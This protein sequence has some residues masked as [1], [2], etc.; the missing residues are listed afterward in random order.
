MLFAIFSVLGIFVLPLLS[1]QL[2][3]SKALPSVTVN[4]SW[5]N[6]SP[7]VLE[8]EITAVL[9]SGF[10]TI[11]GLE[12][13]NSKSSKGSGSI[14]MS[15]D[16]YTD[17]TTARYEIASLIRQLYSELPEN[18][19]YPTTHV[20]RPDEEEKSAFLTYSISAKR[21]P[22]LIH[23]WVK[24]NIEPIIGALEGIDNIQIN[25][26]TANEYILSY[27]NNQLKQLQ[28]S[29]Q[30]LIR[31][32][33]QKFRNESLGTIS[34]NGNFITVSAKPRQEFLEWNFPVGKINNNIIY[35]DDICT[36]EKREKELQSYYRVNGKN[37]ITMSVFASKKVN[38]ITLTNVV[39]KQINS[40]LKT[41]PKDFN[42]TKD[43]DSSLYLKNELNKIYERSIYTLLL[44]L[45]FVWIVSKSI[46]YL[47]VTVIAIFSNISI[48]FILYYL[49]N[50]EIQL[51]SLAG[52][53]ISLGLIVDNCIVMIDHIRHQ[54]NIN[55]FIPILA[56]TLTTIGALSIIYFLDKE[57]SV[58][59]LDF[60]LVIIVNLT[61]SLLVA[62]LLIPALLKKIHLPLKKEKEV[63][64]NI[65]DTFYIKYEKIISQLL[66]FK[67]L[68]IL[69]AILSFGLPFFLLP[70][71]FEENDKWYAK[72]YNTTLGSEWYLE[73]VRPH[74]DTYL[75]GTFRLFSN[76]V[77]ENAY[78]GKNEET[79]LFID[80][81][82]EKG[83]TVHQMNDAFLDI[84]HYLKNFKGIKSFI[85]N[86]E[87]GNYGRIEITFTNDSKPSYPYLVKSKLI[88]KT[89]ELGGMDWNIFGVGR[90]FF[91]NR[92]DA[93]QPV[94][95][96]LEAKG[97]NYKELNRWADTLKTDLETHPR[98]QEVFVRENS[99]VK[100]RPSFEYT[101]NLDKEKLAVLNKSPLLLINELKQLTI[102]KQEDLN[103][104]INGKLMPIRFKSDDSE[105]FDIWHINNVPLDSLLGPVLLKDLS[106]IEK[107]KADEN[108]Y[109][110]NQE[111][112][113]L[114]EFDYT[115]VRKFGSD[116]LKEKLKRLEKKL[117]LG[118][119]FVVAKHRGFKQ[120]QNINYSFLLILVLGIIYLICAI[121]FESLKQPFI[122]LSIVPISFVG[123]FLTF[124]W[125]D[126]NFDQGG[127]ASF[128][129]LSGITVNASIFIVN[130]FNRLKKKYPDMDIKSLYIEAFRQKIFP[131]MLTVLSTI[132]GFIPFVK[133]GQNEVF[134]FALGV[135][136]MGGLLFSLIGILFY[137][138]VFTLKNK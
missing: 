62:L 13:I 21:S 83:S 51:Y 112:I 107:V 6:S 127:M 43:Y 54:K 30:D 11:K 84:E 61:V 90:G 37:A 103:L 10:S 98:I 48:A 124:Y 26:G 60:A 5:P 130:G 121:L 136:T 106:K 4:Y 45:L 16:K 110:E 88:G 12:K 56:A 132:L 77:F 100:S 58:N 104:N 24:L 122:I 126:F 1:I 23:E 42:I 33:S 28:L 120:N 49:F 97:Y 40:A 96:I 129:L 109:K 69:V 114:V 118:Y 35:L 7:Y 116:F 108:I 55:V 71:K 91:N 53:T 2:N 36:V 87:S 99:Y 105:A 57:Y 73:N 59:L 76:Y 75:G 123:V 102:S 85:S 67:K 78:Y 19:T 74:V 31:T 135:G 70:Q 9:E 119:S 20:N 29:K 50:I 80:A 92:G 134:W 41:L 93:S 8:R 47:A 63:T 25:G 138:P 44:L 39:D 82:M 3:P 86:V 125:F 128:V 52:I 34:H 94:N 18:A 79:K 113:C 68:V 133:D 32:I 111:Y 38:T 101:F 81:G 95:F 15:F 27:D 117:P 66:R 137:L 22:L 64:R 46:K 65:K 131:I 72:A 17:I 89:R 14:S 115:G